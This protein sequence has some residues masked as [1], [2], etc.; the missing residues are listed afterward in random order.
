MLVQEIGPMAGPV[1][2]KDKEGN[3]D[4]YSG[5]RQVRAWEDKSMGLRREHAEDHPSTQGSCDVFQAQIKQRLGEVRWPWGQPLEEATYQ[6]LWI[7]CNQ[8]IAGAVERQ[9]QADLASAADNGEETGG[10]CGQL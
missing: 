6:L 4:C 8:Q 3:G 1:K 5:G 7:C 9:G 2:A 10:V